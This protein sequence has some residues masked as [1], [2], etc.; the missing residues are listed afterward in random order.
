MAAPIG[1]GIVEG[2]ASNRPPFFNGTNYTYWKTRMRI[3]LQAV[4]YHIWRVITKGPHQPTHLVNGIIT[5]KSEE[6]WDDNDIKQAELNAKAMNLLFCALDPSEFNRISNCISAKEIW[7]T[8][9]VTHEGTHQVKTTKVNMLIHTYEM[10][11]ME[12]TESISEMYTRFTNIVNGM[13]SLGK[14]ISNGELVNK[15]LRSLPA[16]WDA[17]VTAIEEAKDVNTLP[18]EQ[19]LGS[20]MTYELSLKQKT[21]DND[22]KKKAIAFKSTTKEESSD[23]SEEEADDDETALITRKF[24]RFMRKKKGFYKKRPQKGDHNK[25]KEKEKERDPPICFECKKPGYYKT[26]CPL[27]KKSRRMLRKKAM[28]ATWSESEDSSSDEEQQVVANLCFMANEDNEVNSEPEI[29]FTFNE[30][31]DAFDDLVMEYEKLKLKNKKL[32]KLN[33]ELTKNSDKFSTEIEDLIQENKKLTEHVKTLKNDK[34]NFLKEKDSLKNNRS[35]ETNEKIKKQNKELLLQNKNYKEELEKVKPFVEKFTFS[36]EKLNMLL[37]SQHAVFNKAGLGFKPHNQQKLYKNFFIPAS[38]NIT[39]YACDKLGH[40][41]YICNKRKLNTFEKIWVPK[42][43]NLT[44]PKGPKMTWVP[45]VS[46]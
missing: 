44:N 41:S 10:F 46:T 9:E 12:P 33:Q 6:E 14:I 4:D 30:L 42:G 23:E 22:K 7:D 43:T 37:N 29:E 28:M 35:F 11:R 20:L 13:R 31:H 25:D 3:Y 17:K 26:D 21:V 2:Q 32:R 36:S 8:L 34:D 39:C 16:S 15:L 1:M 40:K 27:L 45:K 19:L 18:L 38:S 24:K 5:P